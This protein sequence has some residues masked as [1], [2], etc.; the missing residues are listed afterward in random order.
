MYP[1]TPPVTD[2][3]DSDSSISFRIPAQL[4]NIWLI[5]ISVRALF[6]TLGFDKTDA[7]QLELA[8]VEAANNIVLHAYQQK[9]NTILEM[10]LSVTEDKVICTFVDQGKPVDF[11]KKHSLLEPS[12]EIQ[13]L[14]ENRRGISIIRKVMDEVSYTRK[15][16]NNILTLVK[17]L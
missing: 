12:N 2:V 15:E 8:V 5:G 13:L 1:S 6:T 7:F 11:L 10:E 9:E 16:Q 4:N 14:A 17:Y 3:I